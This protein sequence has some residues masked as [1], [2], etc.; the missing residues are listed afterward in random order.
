MKMTKYR[1]GK[2]DC[3]DE[4]GFLVDYNTDT[5]MVIYNGRIISLSI[6]MPLELFLNPEDMKKVL[7][8]KEYFEV[9]FGNENFSMG[10]YSHI[11]DI[12]MKLNLHFREFGKLY[13]SLKSIIKEERE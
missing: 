13:H 7:N 3:N 1:I 8:D 9:L 4:Y 12:F 11:N 6:E 2:E 10:G 5:G